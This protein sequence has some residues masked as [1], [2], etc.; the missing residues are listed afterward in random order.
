M[1]S[2]VLA[3]LQFARAEELA[4]APRSW[5]REA[6]LAFLC[7]PPQLQEYYVVREKERDREVRRCQTEAA[8]ARKALAETQK[9]L[10]EARKAAIQQPEATDGIHQSVAA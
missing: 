9:Q 8:E 4:A 7:L 6:K 3:A 1:S 10:E 2:P 5:S